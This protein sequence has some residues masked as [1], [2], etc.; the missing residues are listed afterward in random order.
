MRFES[1]H[2]QQD[3]LWSGSPILAT[4]HIQHELHPHHKWGKFCAYLR[5][6]PGNYVASYFLGGFS[7]VAT[8]IHE[9]M[10]RRPQIFK[11]IQAHLWCYDILPLSDKFIPYYLT[12]ETMISNLLKEAE[13]YGLDLLC[14]K[15]CNYQSI[16]TTQL[17]EGKYKLTTSN[18][19]NDKSGLTVAWQ[20]YRLETGWRFTDITR[21]SFELH[22]QQF[23][24]SEHKPYIPMALECPPGYLLHV[25]WCSGDT[26]SALLE[27]EEWA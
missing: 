9:L 10:G 17:K 6:D 19:L 14:Q 26:A 20:S 4:N 8:G 27:S 2:N 16:Q 1:H 25:A 5:S 11:L 7:N 3:P 18:S 23:K 22:L 13:F 12:K 24:K 21:G 15:I